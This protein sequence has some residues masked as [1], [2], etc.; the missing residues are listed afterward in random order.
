MT[1]LS[2]YAAWVLWVLL[3]VGLGCKCPAE[4]EGIQTAPATAA[5]AGCVNR[6]WS[7]SFL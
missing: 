1:D 6:K 7:A 3:N 4:M 5:G 2:T